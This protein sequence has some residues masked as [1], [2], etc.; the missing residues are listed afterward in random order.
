[1]WQEKANNIKPKWRE[2]G[3]FP[4]A[5]CF[6]AEKAELGRWRKMELISNL[7]FY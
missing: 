5:T 6:A 7:A 1:M 4:W 3:E 2:M